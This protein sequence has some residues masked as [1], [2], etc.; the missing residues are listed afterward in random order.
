M[1]NV[2]QQHVSVIPANMLACYSA[3]SLEHSCLPPAQHDHGKCKI[4]L[5]QGCAH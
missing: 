2:E 5:A 1:V 3:F 4:N